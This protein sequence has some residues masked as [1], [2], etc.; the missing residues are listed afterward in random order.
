[1]TINIINS[2]E[3][4]SLGMF[5]KE[6]RLKSTLVFC[7]QNTQTTSQQYIN[8]YFKYGAARHKT[9]DRPETHDCNKF[10]EETDG[11]YKKRPLTAFMAFYF[12]FWCLLVTNPHTTGLRLFIVLHKMR[13]SCILFVFSTRFDMC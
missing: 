1:M 6:Q 3:C 8:I 4:A 11:K 9:R 7:D 12:Q 13:D 10:Q 5:A 2:L